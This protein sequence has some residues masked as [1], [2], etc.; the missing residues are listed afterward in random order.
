[1]PQSYR[2]AEG[3]LVDQIGEREHGS[4]FPPY[5]YGRECVLVGELFST[6]VKDKTMTWISAAFAEQFGK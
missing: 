3:M 5:F 1:M 2:P 6:T 4:T